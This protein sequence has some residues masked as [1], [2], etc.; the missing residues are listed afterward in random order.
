MTG[1]Y[2]KDDTEPVSNSGR[3]VWKVWIAAQVKEKDIRFINAGSS[4]DI[5]VSAL[6]GRVI[7]GNV[8]HV[9][10]EVDEETQVYS[11][12]FRSVII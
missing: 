10:E 8:Y 6:P 4:L 1:Q 7:K 5:E 3:F 12:Y 9:E 11:R 2:L